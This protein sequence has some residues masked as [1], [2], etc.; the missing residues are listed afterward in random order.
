MPPSGKNDLLFGFIRGPYLKQKRVTP[1]NC[2][3]QTPQ[4]PEIS[5][6]FS[7]IANENAV[8]HSQQP[9]KF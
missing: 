2:A 3:C 7:N 9:A 6:L 4:T 5:S 1:A 8:I